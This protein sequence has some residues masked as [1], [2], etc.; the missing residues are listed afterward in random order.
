MKAV[1]LG[2]GASYGASRNGGF[3]CPLVTG[4]LGAAVAA[5]LT[6]EDYSG[7]PTSDNIAAGGPDP[8][9][10]AQVTGVEYV[11]HLD[12]LKKFVEEQFGLS[13]DSYARSTIDFEKLFALV[14]AELLGYH[15]L[16]QL[17]GAPKRVASPSD[18]LE[19]QF[20]LV[21]CGSII[22]A[23]R[24]LTCDH[25]DR[26]ARWL[27]K[28]DIVASFNYDLIMDRSLRRCTR[29]TPDSGYGIQFSK[30]GV[31]AGDE[32]EWRMP[33]DDESDILLLKPHGS[34]N[35]LYP[36]DSWS[37]ISHMDLYGRLSRRSHQTI[38]CLEDIHAQF[39][40]DHPLYEWWQ[41]YEHSEDNYTF[42]MHAV[43]VPPS[44]SK[45]YRNFEPLVG[46]LW[47]KLLFS[48]LFATRELYIIG[49]S[50]RPDDFRSWWLFRKVA[51]ESETLERVIIVDPSDI[52]LARAK[53]V[54]APRHV[55]R[56]AMSIAEFAAGL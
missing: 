53:E 12:K 25:H 40:D 48:L 4:I 51:C 23:T 54:F 43:L 19:M 46:G 27:R 29:W 21:L 13:E 33:H 2:A 39:E 18:V 49:Y 45:P 17:T 16:L 44:I 50:I 38:F 56:G 31:R 5:G 26:L 14:E 34:L 3:P 35:W 32:A 6:S 8:N 9:I 15:G 47:A 10:V 37:S 42:D 52:V 36:V 28:G 24:D 30:I 55:E 20:M 41:R 7:A 1:I 11:S 22:A